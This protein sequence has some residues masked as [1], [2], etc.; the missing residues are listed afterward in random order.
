MRPPRMDQGQKILFNV[1]SAQSGETTT[2]KRQMETA[3]SL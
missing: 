1:G 3:R 2:D